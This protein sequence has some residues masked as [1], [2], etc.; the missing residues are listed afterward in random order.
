MYMSKSKSKS[1]SKSMTISKSNFQIFK[2]L[3]VFPLF[4]MLLF[5][6]LIAYWIYDHFCDIRNRFNGYKNVSPE[7]IESKKQNFIIY[8]PSNSGKTSLKK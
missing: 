4:I 8:G 7:P 2:M 1:V 3:L 5:I 6:I